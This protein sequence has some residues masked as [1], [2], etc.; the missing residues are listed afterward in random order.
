LKDGRPSAI[1][2]E[3]ESGPER[4][5]VDPERDYGFDLGHLEEHRSRAEPVI[6]KVRERE[7]P[8]VALSIEDG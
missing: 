7:G 5:L 4:I 3:A 6:V 2:V 8:D 1:T